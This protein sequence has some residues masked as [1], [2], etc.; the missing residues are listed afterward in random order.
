[1]RKIDIELIQLAENRS[2]FHDATS[3]SETGK[4]SLDDDS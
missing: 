4:A 2:L 3:I 1:M